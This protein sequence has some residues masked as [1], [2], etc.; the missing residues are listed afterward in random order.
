MFKRFSFHERTAVFV[1]AAVNVPAEVCDVDNETFWTQLWCY[2]LLSMLA[3]ELDLPDSNISAYVP[4]LLTGIQYRD[5]GCEKRE[6][7]VVPYLSILWRKD[8]TAMKIYAMLL[9][10]LF[11]EGLLDG[12]GRILLR[13]ISLSLQLSGK[14][15]IW[16]DNILLKFLVHQQASI[17]HSKQVYL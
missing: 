6:E 2:H 10:F 17:D 9:V 16:I 4:M 1:L 15:T 8:L 7:Y 3:K 11:E 12:R 14:E 5:M 13:N